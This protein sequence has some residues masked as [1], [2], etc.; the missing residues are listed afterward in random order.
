MDRGMMIGR[1]IGW[2][3]GWIGRWVDGWV[4][5]W[6]TGKEIA[7]LGSALQKG[8]L[9]SVREKGRKKTSTPLTEGT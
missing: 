6:M 9:W 5:G 1:V 2:V 8:L 7:E 3:A 4:D